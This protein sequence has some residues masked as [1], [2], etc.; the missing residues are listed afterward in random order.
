MF[1]CCIYSVYIISSL[2]VW[3]WLRKHLPLPDF[4]HRT[5]TSFI[6]V[7]TNGKVNCK[8]SIVAI[9]SPQVLTSEC[10]AGIIPMK[11][12]RKKQN[13]V[14][15]SEEY[16]SQTSPSMLGHIPTIFNVKRF[17]LI[18]H[19]KSTQANKCNVPCTKST[20]NII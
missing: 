1:Y 7:V 2:I 10:I 13:T 8:L 9:M 3:N 19:S 5:I 12:N 15:K 6:I 20:A 14:R 4:F 11:T 17:N 18:A 16:P